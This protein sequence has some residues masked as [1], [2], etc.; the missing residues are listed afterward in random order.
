MNLFDILQK[1]VAAVPDRIVFE[2]EPHGTYS[3]ADIE[4]ASAKVYAY[5]VQKGVTTE[6]IVVIQ[7]KR[8]A[9]VLLT[10][11]GVWKA[12]AAFV[13]IGEYSTEKYVNQ[14][15][16]DAEGG[17]SFTDETYEEAMQ[18]AP[19]T[20]YKAASEHDLACLIYSTGS[21]GFFKGSMHEYG[22]IHHTLKKFQAA[23]EKP[24]YE[25]GEKETRN[26]M[27]YPLYSIDSIVELLFA[28]FF[29]NYY[30]VVPYR[31][32]LSFPRLVTLINEKKIEII[33]VAANNY[34][35]LKQYDLP[36]LKRL[37]LSFD[38]NIDDLDKDCVYTN[39]YALTEAFGWVTSGYVEKGQYDVVPSGPLCPLTKA[40]IC[41]KNG[42]ALQKGEI[43]EICVY[44]EFFRGYRNRPAL[45]AE[46]LHDGWISTGDIGYIDDNDNFVVL[47]RKIDMAETEKGYII[48]T[49]ISVQIKKRFPNI[50]KSYVKVFQN[51]N[52]TKICL[53][54]CGDREYT[55]EEFHAALK[56]N[57]P[58]YM[59]PTHC[60]KKDDFKFLCFGKIDRFSFKEPN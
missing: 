8:S 46:I 3:F 43:G 7:M 41:D 25:T 38:V 45:T 53:Y 59:M 1:N 20:G 29:G 5:L 13:V 31:T 6:D 54:Y 11:L 44:N 40:V 49:L 28:V 26:L 21:S 52:E 4:T 42:V 9:R 10:M 15:L 39:T 19:L 48:P 24:L 23:N 50:T 60:E 12:G 37:D 16:H 58:A 55:L 35:K 36:T 57:L 14:V 34:R 17:F 56:G 51:E 33:C 30:Y 47:G 27:L 18:V 22:T 32:I 2:D